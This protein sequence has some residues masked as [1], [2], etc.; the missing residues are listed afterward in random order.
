MSEVGRVIRGFFGPIAES[1]RVADLERRLGLAE[2]E[3]RCLARLKDAVMSALEDAQ[4]GLADREILLNEARRE[5]DDAKAAARKALEMLLERND[6]IE[7]LRRLVPTARSI[8]RVVE[9]LQP[10]GQVETPVGSSK[11]T[12]GDVG[13]RGRIVGSSSAGEARRERDAEKIDSTRAGAHV[14][15]DSPNLPYKLPR[16]WLEDGWTETGVDENGAE[17]REA[18]KRGH[19]YGPP[20]VDAMA[21][22]E[23][24]QAVARRL[25]RARAAARAYNEGKVREK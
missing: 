24:M 11:E 6:E 16:A 5:R 8:E 7:R 25:E 13:A 21:A 15:A 20:D 3:Y 4:R 19:P 2:A 14:D 9:Y 18:R 10:I 23:E 17:H 1:S 22:D 12:Q